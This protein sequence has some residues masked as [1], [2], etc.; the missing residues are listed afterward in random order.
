MGRGNAWR[1]E[2]LELGLGPRF[3]VHLSVCLSQRSLGWWAPAVAFGS[4]AT[5][6]IFRL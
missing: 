5:F 6:Y 4:S 3:G 1:A 2:R